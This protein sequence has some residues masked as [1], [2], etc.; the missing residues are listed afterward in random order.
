MFST[1][2]DGH[3]TKRPSTTIFFNTEIHNRDRPCCCYLQGLESTVA[4]MRLVEQPDT[5]SFALW[6]D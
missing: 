1:V 3:S 6:L 5:L 4:F 2:L